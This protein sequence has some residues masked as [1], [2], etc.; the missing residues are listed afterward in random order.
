MDNQVNGNYQ[1]E[2]W[3]EQQ[4]ASKVDSTPCAMI[5]SRWNVQITSNA[6]HE[7]VNE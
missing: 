1:K 4:V 6:V 7:S 2:W 5:K 3:N